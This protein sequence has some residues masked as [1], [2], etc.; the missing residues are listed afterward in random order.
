MAT[1]TGFTA[2]RMLEIEDTCIVDGA[3][4]GN[5]LVLEQRNGTP[6]NAGN[7][8]GPTGPTGPIGEVSNAEL[9]AAI[10]THNT[11]EVTAR[12][13]AIAAAIAEKGW[14]HIGEATVSNSAAFTITIPDSTYKMVKVYLS[15][16]VSG[17]ASAINARVN[18]DATASLHRFS[19][20]QVLGDGSLSGGSSDTDMWRLGVANTAFA[21]SFEMTINNA[22]GTS[23]LPW[24]CVNTVFATSAANVRSN[25]S[26]GRLTTGR[27][28]AS[29][30]IIP[31]SGLMTG[32][33]VCEGYKLP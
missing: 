24:Q 26:S 22:D 21:S 27:L 5:D 33:W 16:A 23:T 11:S 30:R 9:T 8:R 20:T 10:S 14:Q 15:L 32:F 13:A 18:N 1:V 3:I 12:N 17:T 28:M 31:S 25:I 19:Y 29:L 4:V 2:E 6:I 7:V